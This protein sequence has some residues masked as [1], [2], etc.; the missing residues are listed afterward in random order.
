MASK[1]LA[2]I[3]VALCLLMACANANA[4][5]PPP[6]DGEQARLWPTGVAIKEIDGKHEKFHLVSLDLAA[7]EHVLTI[8]TK[9][10][11][12]PYFISTLYRVKATFERGHTYSWQFDLYK[13]FYFNDLGV[14]FTIPKM[15]KLFGSVD[16][17]TALEDARS[18]PPQAVEFLRP[19][20]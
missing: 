7:G 11:R 16:Y 4:R 12:H 8:E 2:Y 3:A 15:P 14:D 5:Q 17:N 13:R 19:Q 18:R 9:E 10:Y 6:L 1:T 20:R